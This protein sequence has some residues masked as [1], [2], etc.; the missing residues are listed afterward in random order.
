MG[1]VESTSNKLVFNHDT[2]KLFLRD[3]RFIEVTYT[4][5]SGVAEAVLEKGLVMG[6]VAATEKVLPLVDD[7]TNGSQYPLGILNASQTVA[8]SGTVTLTLCVSGDVDKSL[9]VLPAGTDFN[10]VIE[11][12]TVADRLMSDTKGLFL[13]ISDELSD[14]DNQ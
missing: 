3:N 4:N 9:V 14:Y 7:A 5:P 6:R 11:A 12:K 10:T 2:S 1:L 13:V 8:A